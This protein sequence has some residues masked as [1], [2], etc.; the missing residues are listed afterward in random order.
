MGDISFN[1]LF[2]QLDQLTVGFGPVFREY[3]LG[4][5]HNFPPHNI[6]KISDNEFDLELALA[7]FK[8]NDITIEEYRGVVTIK[9][10]P[11]DFTDEGIEDVKE[12]QYR[13]IARRSFTKSLRIA[14]YFEIKSAN[15]EDGV[16]LIKFIKN[17]PET[18]KPKQITIK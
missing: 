9:S 12:Y 18:E 7:G 16:L 5:T 3:G 1:R 8:K 14:E 4:Q 6:I 15:M 11:I 10:K 13:G 17:E 2:D